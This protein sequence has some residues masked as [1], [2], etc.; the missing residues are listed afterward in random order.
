MLQ[1]KQERF[2]ERKWR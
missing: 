1:L 2:N